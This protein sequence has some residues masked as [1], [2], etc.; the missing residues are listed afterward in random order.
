MKGGSSH[1]SP[2]ATTKKAA[3][4]SR[5]ESKHGEDDDDEGKDQDRA[6]LSNH[7]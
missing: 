6:G 7:R 5:F 1:N 3:T 2:S 4:R